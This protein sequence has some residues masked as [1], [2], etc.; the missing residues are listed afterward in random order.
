MMCR[1]P[2]NERKQQDTGRPNSTNDRNDNNDEKC[3]GFKGIGSDSLEDLVHSSHRG[4]K[5]ADYLT[6]ALDVAF[7]QDHADDT[8]EEDNDDDDDDDTSQAS[9]PSLTS[10]SEDDIRFVNSS[11]VSDDD[12]QSVDQ[13]VVDDGP[14]VLVVESDVLL[15]RKAYQRPLSPIVEPEEL[16][17]EKKNA[18]RWSSHH[19]PSSRKVCFSNIRVCTSEGTG[20]AGRRT[21]RRGDLDLTSCIRPPLTQNKVGSGFGGDT[22]PIAAQR[23]AS[24]NKVA[25]GKAGSCDRLPVAAERKA[26]L[27]PPEL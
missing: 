17:L 7:D 10:F 26:S 6:R 20:R 27:N 23:K 13:S 9:L 2:R 24:L 12:D 3:V 5:A 16:R 22:L 8:D 19:S 18:L 11:A 21:L 15:S 14:T 25:C 4:L 1:T